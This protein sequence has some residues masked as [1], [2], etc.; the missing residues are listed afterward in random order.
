MACISCHTRRFA[1]VSLMSSVK[2]NCETPLLPQEQKE[3][4]LGERYTAGLRQLKPY[5]C[6]LVADAALFTVWKGNAWFDNIHV[7]V[8]RTTI[9]VDTAIVG[10]SQL[11]APGPGSN[12]F[13]TNMTFQGDGRGS[14]MAVSVSVLADSAQAFVPAFHHSVFVQGL[15]PH[16]PFLAINHHS[17][18]KL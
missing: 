17:E 4:G 1:A 16:Y 7:I 8:E 13:L 11:A 12:I 9:Q 5:Q 3:W 10:V 15:L 2:G 18:V 6:V 14:L